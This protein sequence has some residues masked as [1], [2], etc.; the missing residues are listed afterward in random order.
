MHAY[1]SDVLMYMFYEAVSDTEYL[2]NVQ[3]SGALDD[4]NL[5]YASGKPMTLQAVYWTGKVL[6]VGGDHCSTNGTVFPSISFK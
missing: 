2:S 1:E 4:I 5:W 3:D 6:G